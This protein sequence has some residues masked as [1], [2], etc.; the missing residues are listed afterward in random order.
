MLFTDKVTWLGFRWSVWML[1]GWCAVLRALNWKR[2][3]YKGNMADLKHVLLYYWMRDS[4]SF[5]YSTEWGLFWLYWWNEWLFSRWFHSPCHVTPEKT[6]HV[7]TPMHRRTIKEFGTVHWAEAGPLEVLLVPNRG[8]TIK[9]KTFLSPCCLL[10]GHSTHAVPWH[11]CQWALA[12]YGMPLNKQMTH[13][14]I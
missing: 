4:C 5:V 8:K 9:Q 10:E 6:V 12:H 1:H 13:Y 11:A 14:N 7:E 3:F 2:E